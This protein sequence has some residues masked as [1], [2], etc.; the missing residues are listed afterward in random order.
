ME[1]PDDFDL[2]GVNGIPRCQRIGVG[3]TLGDGTQVMYFSHHGDGW[4]ETPWLWTMHRSPTGVWTEVFSEANPDVLYEGLDWQADT[5][6]VAAHASGV[7]IHDTDADG[8]PSL[9][10][11]L[12]GFD[13]ALK[14]QADGDELW[15]SDQQDIKLVDISDPHAA[16]IV[17]TVATHA[18]PRDI[19]L[20]ADRIYIALG[21]SG[22]Q[23][24]DRHTHAQ[25]ALL[26]LDGSAQAVDADDALVAVASW[27]HTRLYDARDFRLVGTENLETAFEQDLGVVLRGER[28]WALQWN[29]VVALDYHRGYVAADA[30]LA[31]DLFS[32]DA[33]TAA[34]I[35]ISVHNRGP[36]DLVVNAV[37]TT[38]RA[39]TTSPDSLVVDPGGEGGIEL[40]YTP[41]ATGNSTLSLATND[42]DAFENPL[43]VS[44]EADDG[45]R[46]DVG[47]KLTDSF[48]F[49][50]PTGQNDLANLEGNVLVL[51]YFALF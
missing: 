3:P 8:V 18:R 23:V 27:T 39:W 36:L 50:D 37:A 14:L 28:I 17:A 40:S 16:S 20:T 49:L 24:F 1:D 42:P 19:H 11:T 25:I 34:K 15:V 48:A 10:T 13:N 29:G 4:V 7:Q 32:F 31:A 46:L 33:D 5:L 35:L 44:L 41:T 6:F 26:E 12:E 30:W 51:A 21:S 45:T 38:D 43:V 22:L 2:D 47:D 9:V